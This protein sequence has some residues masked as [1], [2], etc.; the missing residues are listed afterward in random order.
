[1]ATYEPQT[2]RVVAALN[3]V[4][5]EELVGVFLYGSAVLGGLRPNSDIDLFAVVR[6]PTTDAE[7]RRLVELI[8]P[9]SRRGQRQ[10][11]WRPV[12]LT[13]AVESDV[14]PL[15][16]PPRT[17]FQYG[18]W[19]ER[20]FD[21]GQFAPRKPE[22]EDLVV[23]IAMVVSADHPLR[24]PRPVDLFEPVPPLKL[25]TAML[26]TIDGLLADLD[27]DTANVLLTLARIRATLEAG[28]FMPKDEAADR[29]LDRLP[30]EHR[31]PLVRARAIYLGEQDDWAGHEADARAAAQFIV[32][33]IAQQATRMG[34]RS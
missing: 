11:G 31:P 14:R 9:I 5:G 1:M 6:R 10:A 13:I 8:R 32:A 26:G 18:E 17:D 12:E 25:G 16:S 24:G 4:L 22:N 21:A 27:S 19:L 7:K 28:T 30:E 2:R 23:L 34:L 20:D 33:E 29:E 15:R 3:A